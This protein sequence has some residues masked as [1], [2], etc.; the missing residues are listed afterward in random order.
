MVEGGLG[1]LGGGR[2]FAEEDDG[3]GEVEYATTLRDPPARR[4]HY[5]LQALRAEAS[6]AVQAAAQ[7]IGRDINAACM[8][9]GEKFLFLDVTIDI[10]A[11]MHNFHT[12]AEIRQSLQE[13]NVD[14]LQILT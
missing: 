7:D 8:V 11:A 12:A 14:M 5:D 3:F 1:G 4:W 9:D 10:E 6:A 2:R 13:C